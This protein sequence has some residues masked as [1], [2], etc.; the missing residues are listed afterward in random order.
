[1]C[2]IIIGMEQ[3]LEFFK[4][5]DTYYGGDQNWHTHHMMKLGGCSAVCACEQCIVLA[6][7]FPSLA[8]LYPYDPLHVTKEDFL[9]FF[10]LMFRYI[11]PGIGGLTSIDKFER[12]F[13]RYAQYAGVELA[14]EKL[15]GHAGALQAE[16]FVRR[17]IGDGVPVMY[18]MLKHADIAF[19]EYEWHWFNLTGYKTCGREMET[20]FATWGRKCSFDFAAAWDTGK[21]WRGGMLRIAKGCLE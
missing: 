2:V 4:I 11:Y 5:D 7:S 16:E 9:K 15:D 19:D 8:K 17:A 12:M 6:R 1:M 18:L 21:F 10:E 20:T 13:L 3:E 14:F